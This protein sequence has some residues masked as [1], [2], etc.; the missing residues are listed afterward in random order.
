MTTQ[1]GCKEAGE[2]DVHDNGTYT[3]NST[4]KGEG[5]SEEEV[6]LSY[7][8]VFESSKFRSSLEHTFL[9][10]SA[11]NTQEFEVT[12]GKRGVKCKK[13]SL[14]KNTSTILEGDKATEQ[15]TVGP[16]YS[17]CES[18]NSLPVALHVEPTGC[19]YLYTDDT[20][21]L[22]EADVHVVCQNDEEE[23][24]VKATELKV[25][26]MTIPGRNTANVGSGVNQNLT[27]VRYIN[28]GNH[29]DVEAYVTGITSTT[30]GACK[31]SGQPD[32]HTDGIYK[33]KFTMS[34]TGTSGETANL[35][36]S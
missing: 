18:Y 24:H 5:T 31:E 28:N 30:Q 8:E 12:F 14:N 34:G 23:I 26:C 19:H 15:L 6:D 20:T 1:G 16:E 33:G 10:A 22:E 25:V 21:V 13:L 27:G 11:V 7:E 32:T 17:E 9:S 35:D 36:F 2:P 3:G 4:L 29:I